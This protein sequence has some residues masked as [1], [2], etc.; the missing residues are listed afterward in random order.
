MWEAY[1]QPQNQNIFKKKVY[2]TIQLV[3]KS[4]QIK[5]IIIDFWDNWLIMKDVASKQPY[6]SFL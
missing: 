5:L 6:F 2:I 3:W 1:S 4:L